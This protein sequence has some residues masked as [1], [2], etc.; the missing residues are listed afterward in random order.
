MNNNKKNV[1]VFPC[2]VYPALQVIDCLKHCLQVHVIAGASYSNHA[3]F[4]C[5]DTISDMPF[6][7]D[8]KFLDYLC[9]LI[10]ARSIDLIIP[11]DDTTA[12]FFSEHADEIPATIVCSP[13]ETSQL[14][15]MKSLDRKSVV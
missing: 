5:D 4:I 13:Y 9:D 7:N 8:E 2:P 11:T 14:C 1:L 6:I 12:L 15:R 10:K 3:E